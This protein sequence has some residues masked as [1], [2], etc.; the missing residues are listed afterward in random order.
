M[1]K[2]C[3]LLTGSSARWRTPAGT[4]SIKERWTTAR[5]SGAR[6]FDPGVECVN[7][8]TSLRWANNGI[9]IA[10]KRARDNAYNAEHKEEHGARSKRSTANRPDEVKAYRKD[11]YCANREVAIE[12]TRAW[13]KQNPDRI[14]DRN[15]KRLEAR[16]PTPRQLA[17]AERAA[18]PKPIKPVTLVQLRAAAMAAGAVKFDAGLPCRRGHSSQRYASSGECVAC[19]KAAEIASREANR[20]KSRAR[21]RRYYAANPE[22]ALANV[23]HRRARKLNAEIGCRKS[24]A[25][26]SKW[27]RNAKC[28]RCYWC[29][30][31]T[32]VKKRHLDHIIPLAKGGADSV[33]NLCVS[34][35]NCNRRKSAKLPFEFVGQ[36]EMSLA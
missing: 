27:A 33:A 18:M 25:V 31:Q 6:T 12:R 4:P 17:T 19:C 34:C 36:A 1:T 28:L 29:H 24:Y 32:K 10:C 26:F 15:R 2:N 30:R 8:H 11:Y 9:C 3:K 20:P 21:L 16:G 5:L 13:A 23:H 14:R 35:P 22:K 7:G